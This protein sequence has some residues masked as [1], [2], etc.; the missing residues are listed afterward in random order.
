M[1]YFLRPKVRY[2]LSSPALSATKSQLPSLSPV[3][4]MSS[5]EEPPSNEGLTMAKSGMLLIIALV[6][7]VIVYVVVLKGVKPSADKAAFLTSKDDNGVVS[8]SHAK[9]A[10][11]SGVVGVLVALI[12]HVV[13]P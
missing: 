11:L 3:G 1:V 2:N 10:A 5:M 8:V 12:S 9:V 7:A 13:S 4:S 6:V